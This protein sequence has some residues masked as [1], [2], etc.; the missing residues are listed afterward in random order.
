MFTSNEVLIS[1]N[2]DPRAVTITECTVIE[3]LDKVN[4][5][6]YKSG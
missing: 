6:K 2:N 5:V 1:Y 3:T 4:K